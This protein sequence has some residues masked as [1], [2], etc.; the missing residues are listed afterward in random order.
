M[1]MSMLCKGAF[2]G[3]FACLLLT[4]AESGWG[5]T[6]AA[7]AVR[8]ASPFNDHMVLQRGRPVPVWGVAEP[9]ADVSVTFAGQAVR[10]VADKAGCWR[11]TLASMPAS[12]ESRT[13]SVTAADRSGERR[14]AASVADV[15]VGEVWI[16]SGQSNCELPL[17]GATPH[18][19]DRNGPLVA[20]MTH[21][22]Y[23]RFANASSCQYS[24]KPRDELRMRPVWKPFD[25]KSL[26]EGRNFSA[27][28]VYFAL[29]VQP[30]IDVPVG[31]FGV[32]WG[33]TRIEPWI[34]SEDLSGVKGSEWCLAESV[35]EAKDWSGKRFGG[36]LSSA[37]NQPAVLWNDMVAPLCPMAFRG[38]LWYQGCSN[39]QSPDI[40][41]NENYRLL[42]HRLY[43][44]WSK[45]FENPSMKLYF[46]QLAPFSRNWWDIQLAQAQFAAEEKN[47][48]MVTTCD[49]G[50]LS[51]I[52]PNEK[53]T[54]G[55]RLAALALRYDYGF[56]ELVADAPV[57][58][59][60]RAVSNVV[61][62]TFAD[63]KSWWLYNR[64]WSVDVP[65][66][67]AAEDGTWHKA[68]L[69]NTI[70]GQSKTKQW[71]SNGRIDGGAVLRLVADGVSRPVRVRHLARHPW[72][73]YLY[74]VD[75]GLP[76][77]PFEAKVERG[78]A[79]ADGTRN[80]L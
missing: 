65:F 5:V 10:T 14:S 36:R 72:S 55:K 40:G 63:A 70:N 12:K 71:H 50:N 68:R 46:V 61:E 62:M 29:D 67:L 41:M 74:S 56:S 57:L 30:E 34:S 47:A 77:G 43:D 26:R 42:M 78:A 15:L 27:M 37:Q 17:V 45:R 4:A 52:H 22:P 80:V 38:V 28:G 1:K 75:S 31:L 11:V 69:V 3:G 32:Y 19:G 49:I 7:A 58:K 23:I 60:C 20:N 8:L 18:F 59:T 21:R 76:L 39:S 54:I 2:R 16:V 35:V 9:N 24:L 44:S 53:G 73:G 6:N 79:L 33:G 25:P 51:D 64:D 13:L 66:E 48:A